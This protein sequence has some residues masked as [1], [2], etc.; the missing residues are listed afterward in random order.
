MSSQMTYE[1]LD[2]TYTQATLQILDLKLRN[3]ELLE[4]I[5]I[6]KLQISVGKV[7][8]YQPKVDKNRK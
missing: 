5:E 8:Y 4:E 3:Q 6:L 1:E 2:K 7:E